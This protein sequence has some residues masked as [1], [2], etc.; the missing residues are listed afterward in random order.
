M[1]G[2]LSGKVSNVSS[3]QWSENGRLLL[4]RW[5]QYFFAILI[6]NIGTWCIGS[7][8]TISVASSIKLVSIVPLVGTRISYIQYANR[9]TCLKGRTETSAS[10]DARWGFKPR[11]DYNSTHRRSLS[12]LV[13]F[14]AAFQQPR[15]MNHR[16]IWSNEMS[17]KLKCKC[18]WCMWRRR[19]VV[20][21]LS[22]CFNGLLMC[23]LQMLH[24]KFQ[25]VVYSYS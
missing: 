19:Q 21:N 5:P 1:M 18:W 13:L 22:C 25:S 3:W 2:I 11:I 17:Q 16:S 4:L 15:R 10:V 23:M 24:F 7:R 20:H 8:T 9:G 6:R 12:L 14:G